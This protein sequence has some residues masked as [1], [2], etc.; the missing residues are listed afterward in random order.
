[1]EQTLYECYIFVQNGTEM[2]KATTANVSKVYDTVEREEAR[3]YNP[4]V[5]S[6]V[7]TKV[8]LVYPYFLVGVSTV[9]SIYGWGVV[10]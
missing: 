4:F 2:L 8:K 7:K 3:L 1:M 9:S 10:G 5:V 6:L